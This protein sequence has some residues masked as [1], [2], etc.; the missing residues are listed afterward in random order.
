MKFRNKK[1]T[2]WWII[3]LMN[4]KWEHWDSFKTAREAYKS[5]KEEYFNEDH[6]AVVQVEMTIVLRGEK[7]H[8]GDW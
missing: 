3:K 6:F 5:L 8:A 1:R 2:E 4:G 7:K